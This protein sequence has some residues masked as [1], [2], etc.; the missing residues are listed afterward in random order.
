VSNDK[1][2]QA[3]SATAGIPLPSTRS[4]DSENSHLNSLRLD[5][6]DASVSLKTLTFRHVM[7]DVLGREYFMKFLK[8]EHAEENLEFYE[9]SDLT[10]R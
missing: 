5:V 3:K 9:V 2:S 10:S 6:G 1:L 4:A 7:N 8:M